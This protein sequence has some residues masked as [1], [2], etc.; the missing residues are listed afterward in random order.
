MIFP[1]IPPPTTLTQ[2]TQTQL[3]TKTNHL[4]QP[5]ISKN[6]LHPHPLLHIFISPTQHIHSLFPPKPL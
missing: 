1:A 6:Q 2:H 3:L 4:L 5:I